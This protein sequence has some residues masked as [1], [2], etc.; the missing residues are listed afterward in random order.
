MNQYEDALL[1]ALD[2]LGQIVFKDDEKDFPR[3]AFPGHPS[4][5]HHWQWGLLMQG[6]ARTV[7]VLSELFDVLDVFGPP[8]A[9]DPV[10]VQF[11]QV[12]GG[13]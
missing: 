11:E 9:A 1:R 10:E 2:R 5:L 6:G 4:P 7:R 12:I 13:R 3:F 8:R